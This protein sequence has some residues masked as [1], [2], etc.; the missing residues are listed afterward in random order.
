M[1][2]ALNLSVTEQND[3]KVV[4]FTDTSTG[5][6]TGGD[7]SYTDIEA[8]TSQTYSL[9]LS[10]TINT[11]SG[12]TVYDT[13][14][15]YGKGL[16]TPFASQDDLVF[17]IDATILLESGEAM[18]DSDYLLPDGVWDIVYKVQHYETGSWVDVDSKSMSLLVYGQV[19]TDVYD[20]LRLVPRWTESEVSKYRDIQEASYYYTY[21]QSI[22]KSAFIARKEDLLEFLETLQRLLINGSNYP[23]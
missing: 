4:T 17:A 12:S 7:P 10:I 1:A 19:K 6:D 14:D 20:K 3:S 13:I 18:G 16:N 21:L 9:T 23:W 5:W 11:P 15:L 8:R 22:E 2:L